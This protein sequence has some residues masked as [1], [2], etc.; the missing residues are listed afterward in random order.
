MEKVSRAELLKELDDIKKKGEDFF[1]K[2]TEVIGVEV[3]EVDQ[4]AA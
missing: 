1:N 4:V 3:T 2:A